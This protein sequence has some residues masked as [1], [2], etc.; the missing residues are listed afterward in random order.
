MTSSM[1]E[2]WLPLPVRTQAT[3]AEARGVI[4]GARRT[5]TSRLC[6]RLDA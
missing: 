1:T 5:V 2:L 4:D 3:S 6:P